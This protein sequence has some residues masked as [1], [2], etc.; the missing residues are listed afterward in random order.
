[1]IQQFPNPSPSPPEGL[2]EAGWRVPVVGWRTWTAR[3]VPGGAVLEGVFTRDRWGAGSTHAGCRRCPPWMAKLHP[4]PTSACQCGLYAFSTPAQALSYLD[5]P[6]DARE[7]GERADLVA[8]AVI[9]WGRVVQHGGQGWR[10]EHA[11]PVALLDSGH[12]FLEM[13]A[14]HHNVP[15]VSARGLSL[16]PLEYGEAF[17]A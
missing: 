12:P 10:A 14:R 16:L 7:G 5:T 6:E 9:A 17:T 4:V 15:V 1:M 8:G 13:L 11:R 2:T 3:R